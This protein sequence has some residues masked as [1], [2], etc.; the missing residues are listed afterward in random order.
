M[1]N[2]DTPLGAIIT[3]E[4]LAL[5]G[6]NRVSQTKLAR[7][8]GMSQPQLSERLN[9][10]VSWRVHELEAVAAYFNVSVASLLGSLANVNPNLRWTMHSDHLTSENAAV[11]TPFQLPLDFDSLERRS[12]LTSVAP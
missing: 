5:M 3:G 1:S 9:G 6:R 8:I 7:A 10:Q 12:R 11:D 4:V 2:H